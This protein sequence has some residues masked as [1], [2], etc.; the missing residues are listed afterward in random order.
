MIREQ[1]IMKTEVVFNDS[2]SERYLLRKV[3]D[4]SKPIVC[5]IMTNPSTADAVTVDMTVHYAICNLFKLG[6]GGM[7][8][9]NMTSEITAK[10]DA[11]N[12]ICLSDT[13]LEYIL[14]SA[15]PADKVIIA[16]GKIGENNKKIKALQHSLLQKLTPF[17][18]KM[19]LIANLDG[20]TG[21]HPL[22]PQIRFDWILVPFTMP[23]YLKDM[24]ESTG[25]SNTGDLNSV[26][27]TDNKGSVPVESKGNEPDDHARHYKGKRSKRDVMTA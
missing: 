6:Y 22:A 27:P 12:G 1:G 18:D 21:F 13:N 2:K 4:E 19:Y 15:E 25:G 14:R 24:E 5:L 26:E 3:W 23:D 17:K 8:I 10:L 20:D 9:L 7:D 11:K 16:W